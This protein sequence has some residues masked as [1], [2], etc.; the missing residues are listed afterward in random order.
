M[1]KPIIVKTANFGGRQ[2]DEWIEGE[3]LQHFKGL[4]KCCQRGLLVELLKLH[5]KDSKTL[6]KDIERL[7]RE[8]IIEK[9]VK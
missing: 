7:C 2:V 5:F 4:E 1:A 3:F 9:I 8:A 6:E